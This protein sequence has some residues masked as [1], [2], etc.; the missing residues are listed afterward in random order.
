MKCGI[1]V[2]ATDEDTAAIA[3][4]AWPVLE[5]AGERLSRD[6]GGVMEHLWID[7][8]LCAT[9]AELSPPH[10]FRFQRRVSLKNSRKAFGLPELHDRPDPTNVGH[11]SVYPDF[12]KLGTMNVA[13]APAYLLEIVHGASVVLEARARKLG[14][15]DARAFRRDLQHIVHELRTAP[16]QTSA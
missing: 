1:Y 12:E 4:A 11:F 10:G 2:G 8:G 3:G 6:Y 14:G 16:K 13:D 5:A 7:I 15:F 9:L